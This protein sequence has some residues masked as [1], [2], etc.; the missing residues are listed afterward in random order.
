MGS[1]KPLYQWP[2]LQRLYLQS[3]T[4]QSLK[5][6]GTKLI[7]V[8]KT[9]K[10]CYYEGHHVNENLNICSLTRKFYLLVRMQLETPILSY[11]DSSINYQ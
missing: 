5:N 10:I 2:I 11:Q 6:V 9:V 3:V 1:Q 7:H 8:S 4:E